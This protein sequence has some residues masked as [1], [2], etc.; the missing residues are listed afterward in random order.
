MKA[1]FRRG[2]GGAPDD[3][4]VDCVYQPIRN[5]GWPGRRDFIH[6]VEVTG[7]V[8]ARKAVELA[9]EREKREREVAEFERNQLRE[10]FKQAPAG[11]AILSGPEHRW[12]FANTTYCKIV[13]PI[14]GT[15]SELYDTGIST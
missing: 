15:P 7:Q 12:S 4:Y 3:A 13:G 6:T 9:N 2:P 11:I 1:T 5:P 10:L 14:S 8:L